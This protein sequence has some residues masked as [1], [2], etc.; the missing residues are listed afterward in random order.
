MMAD[1]KV[2][3]PR[4]LDDKNE[5]IPRKYAKSIE[6]EVDE[7]VE[8]QFE[9]HRNSSPLVS[10]DRFE[11]SNLDSL[12]D[13]SEQDDNSIIDNKKKLPAFQY[14]KEVFDMKCEWAECDF[15][16]LKVLQ[17]VQHVSTHQPQIENRDSGTMY[18]CL[19]DSC[20]F[21]SSSHDTV[22]RHINYHAYHTKIKSIGSS[23]MKRSNLPTCA[24]DYAGRNLLPVL[25][26]R[27]NCEWEDCDF[28][29]NSFQNFIDHVQCHVIALPKG[30][31]NIYTKESDVKPICEWR[32]CNKQ[33]GDGHKLKEHVRT[34]TQEKLVG[35]P[36]CGTQFSNKTKFYDHCKRQMANEKKGFKCSHC[37][38]N[39]ASERILR[40]HFRLHVNLFKCPF[41][42]MTCPFQSTLALHIRYRHIDL[43]PFQ[44]NFCE[45]RSK[46]QRDLENHQLTHCSENFWVCEQEDCDYSCRNKI[47]LQ[48]HY[49]KNHANIDLFQYCCHICPERYKRGADLTVHL[50]KEHSYRWASGHSRFKYIRDEDGMFRLQ[51]VRYESIE[52]TQ[53]MMNMKTKDLEPLDGKQYKCTFNAPT[54]L[55]IEETEERHSREEPENCDSSFE[56]E[57]FVANTREN[58]NGE[59]PLKI[60]GTDKDK[61][62]DN[63]KN[64]DQDSNDSNFGESLKKYL[65]LTGTSNFIEVVKSEFLEKH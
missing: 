30:K 4:L 50:K 31:R 11:D 40:D 15:E 3:K 25:P 18:C 53:E 20:G 49:A 28:E 38:K 43:K 39:F 17:F 44:C 45:H 33:F 2:K 16:S 65:K 59:D 61:D 52:V 62:K 60:D 58:D 46:T 55:V 26:A 57:I 6:A 56:A 27:L 34:H 54:N 9:R 19:W 36:V 23:I 41:C 64:Q 51:T 47:V 14:S 13:P 1:R 48:E 22:L 7:W 42:D 32:A 37:R 12:D 29:S 35:C 8:Q 5:K 21:D 10:S 63:D 24:L